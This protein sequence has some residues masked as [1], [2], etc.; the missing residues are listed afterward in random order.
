MKKILFLTLLGMFCLVFLP[1]VYAADLAPGDLIKASSSAVYYYGVDAKRYVFP[2]L[3]TYETWY[4]NF[5]EVKEITDEELAAIPI[6][7]NVT[8]R[9]GTKMVKI[10][11]DPKVYAVSQDGTLRW[12]TTEAIAECLYGAD[13]EDLVADISD[14]FFINYTIGQPITDC[15]D[16]DKEEAMDSVQT[17]DMDKS[18]V[19]ETQE[20]EEQQ[21]PQAP[22]ETEEIAEP[23]DS[24]E[25]STTQPIAQPPVSFG[26]APEPGFIG[27][28]ADIAD[29]EYAT[30]LVQMGATDQKALRVLGQA[31]NQAFKITE[32]TISVGGSGAVNVASISI[33]YPTDAGQTTYETK[34]SAVVGGIASFTLMN[35]YVP[36]GVDSYMSAMVNVQTDAAGA[37]AGNNPFTLTLE[38]QDADLNPAI[39]ALTK[40]QCLATGSFATANN[41]GDSDSTGNPLY[42]RKTIL[43]FSLNIASPQRIDAV[44]SLDYYLIF[45]LSNSNGNVSTINHLT[46]K[47][48]A[49]DFAGTDWACSIPST[50]E[51]YDTGD[52]STDL[53]ANATI[54]ATPSATS[55]LGAGPDIIEVVVEL[56]NPG[57]AGS[58]PM[59]INPTTSKSYRVVLNTTGA[60]SVLDDAITVDLIS[61]DTAGAG[62]CDDSDV[63]TIKNNNCLEWLDGSGLASNGYLLENLPVNGL[64]TSF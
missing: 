59:N 41:A 13:W 7:G 3:K 28:S 19:S 31:T 35:W 42:A 10:N 63:D 62:G 16:Y 11:T 23:I 24:T 25:E 40:A 30:R 54:T 29:S 15:A 55:C 34:S 51:L 64:G 48:S 2:D 12:V 22:Q 39:N 58:S 4:A 38:S 8:F 20:T 49:S 17:I 52:L 9:P 6:G 60:S 44:P 18:L 43:D 5:S 46:F 47:L 45:D 57:L 27:L 56:D 1:A 36:A 14:A 32:A 21:E 37:L 33:S 26:G 61:N 50:L 53:A